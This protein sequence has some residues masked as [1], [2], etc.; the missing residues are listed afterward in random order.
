MLT[1]NT[2]SEERGEA[3]CAKN[4]YEYGACVHSLYESELK[5]LKAITSELNH[6]ISDE[7]EELF[8]HSN[9]SWSDYYTSFCE[10]ENMDNR[11]TTGWQSNLNECMSEKIRSRVSELKRLI[12]FKKED[13]EPL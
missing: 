12:R 13:Q 5:K 2:W 9:E 1:F 7:E 11:G 8:R 4:G 6:L 10:L 3:N